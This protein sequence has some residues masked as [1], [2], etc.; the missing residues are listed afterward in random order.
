MSWV[1]CVVPT[2][3]ILGVF[4]GLYDFLEDWV[5]PN[6]RWDFTDIRVNEINLFSV[7]VCCSLDDLKSIEGVFVSFSW[8]NNF[9]GNLRIYIFCFLIAENL[10][11]YSSQLRILKKKR[12]L[13]DISE[14]Q[15]QK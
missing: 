13:K 15:P 11:G 9:E 14:V 2:F 12:K 8:I 5:R 10:K 1:V 3:Y 4:R 6:S 7:R